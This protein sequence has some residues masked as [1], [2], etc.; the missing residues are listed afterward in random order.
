[1]NKPTVMILIPALNEEAHITELVLSCLNQ[2]AES[3]ELGG[4]IVASDGSTDNTVGNLVALHNKKIQII[5]GTER[6]GKAARLNEMLISLQADIAVLLDAD[7]L[8]LKPD[9]VERMVKPIIEGRA[10]MTSSALKELPG[11]T[12]FEASLKVSMKL[13]QVL[14]NALR[15]GHNVYN[16]HGPARAIN[17]K[18]Y[19]QILFPESDGEDIY[20]F[21]RLKELGGIFHYVRKAA[22]GYR[23][24][25]VP[26]DHYKQSIRYHNAIDKMH[27]YFD[28]TF[29]N[30]ELTIPFPV[31]AIAT[32]KSI[33]TLLRYPIHIT[34][35]IAT[36][37]IVKS[38]KLLSLKPKEMW[39]VSSS[40]N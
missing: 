5:N 37:M 20:S 18:F 40:K 19:K 3:F 14:F 21:L 6:K 27:V 22:V 25:S 1:M 24:P 34:A 35:Y 38:G 13:K 16:C 2:N 28:S 8:L 9:F 29:V 15:N 23:L 30:Q 12:F 10:D 7:V 36:L 26:K 31:Y 4:V 17:K 11:R 32:V 39:I 33:P